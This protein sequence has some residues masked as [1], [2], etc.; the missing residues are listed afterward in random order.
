MLSLYFTRKAPM[1]E[2]LSS[3]P[4]ALTHDFSLPNGLR[5]ILREDHR[6]PVVACHLCYKVGSA[7]EPPGQSGMSHALEHLMFEG[8]SKLDARQAGSL[9]ERLGAEENAFTTQDMTVFHQTL[10]SHYLEVALEIGADMMSSALLPDAT[11]S[12]EIEVIKVERGLRIDSSADTIAHERFRSAAHLMSGYRT[13]VIGWQSDLERLSNAQVRQWYRQWYTPSN[14]TL[15]VVGDMQL[16]TLKAMAQR[17]FAH[18]PAGDPVAYQR[19][20][21]LQAPGERRLNLSLAGATP[22]LLLGINVPSLATASDAHSI[23]ALRLLAIILGVGVSSRLVA[24]LVRGEEVLT[25][26]SIDYNANACGDTALELTARPR[27]G[28]GLAALEEKVWA[29]FQLLASEQ[30]SLAELERARAQLQ[31]SLV[32]GRDSLQTQ[33]EQ[34]SEIALAGLPLSLLDNEQSAL[35]QVTPTDIRNAARKWFIRD[36][37]CV[38]HIMPKEDSHE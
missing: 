28:I 38:A 14:A 29:Q 1:P 8:S 26:L 15:V 4:P 11:F 21:E 10:A 20:L 37:L 7:Q 6:A 23:N 19:P 36:S 17:Q 35:Q 31:A 33:A 18:L 27:N 9:L 30:V 5:V 13:P 34:L 3:S 16:A 25:A 2:A 12:R 32:F 24:R 22:G